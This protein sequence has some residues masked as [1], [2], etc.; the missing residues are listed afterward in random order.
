MLWY[1]EQTVPEPGCTATVS[2]WIGPQMMAFYNALIDP[3]ALAAT[4]S[5]LAV[6]GSAAAT[7]LAVGTTALA[8]S[9]AATGFDRQFRGGSGV[10]NRG[11]RRADSRTD[12]GPARS[13]MSATALRR[14]N[15]RRRWRMWARRHRTSSGR[16]LSL[17]E[18]KT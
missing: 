4:S 15:R 5:T 6:A 12:T 10:H 7:G 9:T 13:A 18:H 8:A 1:V 14:R 16:A 2:L 3:I 11:H 17:P